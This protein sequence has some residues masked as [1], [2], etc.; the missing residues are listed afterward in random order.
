M[1][2]FRINDTLL[3][4]PTSERILDGVTRKSVIQLAKDA[5]VDVQVRPVLVSEVV[6]A[7]QNGSLKE[8]FG[9]GNCG[10]DKPCKCL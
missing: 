4:A 7:A 2:F 6:A 1:C 10:C 5:G 9:A 3:T 8:I